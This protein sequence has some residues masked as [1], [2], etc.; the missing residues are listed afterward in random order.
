MKDTEV[1]H[2]E[3]YFAYKE[4]LKE[5]LIKKYDVELVLH[6]HHIIPKCLGGDNSKSNLIKLS[7]EDHIKAHIL[8]SEC[9]DIG[10]KEHI[11]NLRSARILNKN[12]IIDRETLNKISKT[13]M[14]ENNPFY[15]KYHTQDV[16][17][18]VI[19]N[20]K[21]RKGQSYEEIYGDNCELEKK[22][23]STSS[24]AIWA[25]RTV[26]EKAS[27]AS[28]SA[29][30]NKGRIPWNKGK[31]KQIIVDGVKFDSFASA[32]EYHKTSK[33]LLLKNHNVIIGGNE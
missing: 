6:K 23:R 4:F 11:S 2:V 22:K 28:K 12:S 17:D 26:E 7:V 29:I 10:S 3:Q 27:I 14:G 24:K 33:F 13:Y 8:L 16:I 21:K 25:N 9:F 31:G 1:L 30:K 18:K 19:E 32:I 20:N 15:G 5:C